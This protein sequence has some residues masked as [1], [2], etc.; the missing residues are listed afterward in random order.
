MV[1]I[2]I[3]SVLIKALPKSFLRYKS[4]LETAG[5][6]HSV[7]LAGGSL[8]HFG[9]GQGAQGCPSVSN[10]SLRCHYRVLRRSIRSAGQGFWGNEKLFYL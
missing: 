2:F 8:T 5:I 3:F 9:L 10:P 4:L 6:L 1:N 7:A